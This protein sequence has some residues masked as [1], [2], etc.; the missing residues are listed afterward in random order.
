MNRVVITSLLL[1]LCLSTF[2]AVGKDSPLRSIQGQWK[3][4]SV[5]VGQVAPGTKVAFLGHDV[6][7]SSDGYFVLGLGR[8]AKSPVELV[9]T[10]SQ[11]NDFRLNKVVVQRQYK[12]QRVEGVPSRTVNPDQQH[13]DRIY[14]EIAQTKRARAVISQRQEY[15]DNFEWPLTG[16]ITGVYGSQRYYNGQPRR[17]HFGV[18]VAAPTGTV[19]TAPVGGKVTLVHEN[20]FFSGGTLIIDHGQGLNSSF[21]HLSKIL[22]TE[23]QEVKQGDPIAEVGATGRVTGPHL[24]WRMN[25]MDQRVDPQ[26]L[27]PPMES[28]R[29]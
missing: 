11:G 3:Q 9:L 27:V 7:V 14:K 17:P 1:T 8:D 5:L 23:G 19:V 10:D 25:W 15:R 28:V 18:D 29:K 4:G 12:I 21:I 6:M 26:L 22:V 2:N 16:P 24:D 20:M 13:L